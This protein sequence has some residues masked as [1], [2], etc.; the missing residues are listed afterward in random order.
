MKELFL[1]KQNTSKLS[2]VHYIFLY[3]YVLHKLLLATVTIN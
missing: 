1:I 3:G 2:K